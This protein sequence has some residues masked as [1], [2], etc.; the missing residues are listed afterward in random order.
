[1]IV[2]TLPLRTPRMTRHWLSTATT[3]YFSSNSSPLLAV[4][5]YWMLKFRQKSRTFS[6]RSHFGKALVL[7]LNV[8]MGVIRF[9][10]LRDRYYNRL[11]VLSAQSRCE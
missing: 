1:M 6:M 4:I 7:I 10:K 9:P 11:S 8:G 5:L 3:L 2:S